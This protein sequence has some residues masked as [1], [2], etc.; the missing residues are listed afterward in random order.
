MKKLGDDMWREALNIRSVAMKMAWY[1][2]GS[3]QYVDVLNLSTD[4]FNLFN[5]L[6]DSNLETTKKSKLPFF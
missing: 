4:E 2:R 1:S 6:I 3:M 5:K